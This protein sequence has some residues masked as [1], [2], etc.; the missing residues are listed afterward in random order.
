MRWSVLDILAAAGV[1]I[2]NNYEWL[3]IILKIKRHGSE[4]DIIQ[5]QEGQL[6]GSQAH[7]GKIEEGGTRA[8]HYRFQESKT[9]QAICKEAT[10]EGGKEESQGV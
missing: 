10:E 5:P 2:F 8:N 6:L 3:F 4:R 1:D 9:D 7:Q